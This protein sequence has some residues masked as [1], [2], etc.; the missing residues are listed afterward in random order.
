MKKTISLLLVLLV[1]LCPC[2]MRA[3]AA[4]ETWSLKDAS[5]TVD[6]TEN[7]TVSVELVCDKAGTCYGLQGK[8]S[9]SAGEGKLTLAELN[10]A[11]KVSPNENST[12]NGNVLWLDFTYSAGISTAAGEAIWTAVYTVDKDTPSGE[13]TVTFENVNIINGSGDGVSVGTLTARITVVNASSASGA[14][15]SV[16]ALEV[17]DAGGAAQ[18]AIPAESFLVT[19]PVT[20]LA[21]EGSC[22][23]LLASYTAD[24]QF[25]GKLMYVSLE[26]A[27]VGTTVKVTLFVD[28]AGG[29]VG[30]LKAFC[31]SS[32][33]DMTPLS[34]AS[35]FPAGT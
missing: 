24:G 29:R 5:V 31:V 6:G 8:W 35:A 20:R 19:V 14:V 1:L 10:P 13:Y 33:L 3:A 7:K 4:G 16:G 28:N 15:Y 22:M 11:S 17:R 27:P 2:A 18:S 21:G 25:L 23:V 34:V 9:V 32:F 30:R 12:E 26:G